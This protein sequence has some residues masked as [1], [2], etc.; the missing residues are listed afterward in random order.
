M[1]EKI[2]EKL[3]ILDE[4]AKTLLAVRAK[5]NCLQG[6]VKKISVIPLT[7]DFQLE[8][9]K[10]IATS[11]S[12]TESKITKD[13]SHGIKK[14]KRYVS[15]KSM[16]EPKKSDFEKSNLRSHFVPT[17]IKIQEIKSIEPVEEY[18]KSRSIRSFHF[19]KDTTENKISSKDE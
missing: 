6:K 2:L 12:E 14:T 7:F 1:A 4:Q 19:L 16:P 5:K 9:E 8:F 3:D 10:D 18:L 15:F 11:I 17:N 13:R